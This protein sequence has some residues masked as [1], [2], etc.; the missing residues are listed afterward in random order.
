MLSLVTGSST[1]IGLEM[2]RRVLANGDIAVATLRKSAALAS[3]AAQYGPDRLLVLP[4]DVTVPAD[5]VA[6]FKAAADAF[7]RIDVVVSNAGVS[8]LSEIE[9]TPD[10]AARA[11]FEVNF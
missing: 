2:T 10:E 4:V 9:G 3:L 8:V 7:G 11:V 1:G 5:I 6:A